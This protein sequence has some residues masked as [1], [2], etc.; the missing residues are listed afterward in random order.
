MKRILI[1]T[2]HLDDFEFGMGGT[3]AK[4]AAES[5]NEIGLVVMC[6]G[7]RPGNEHVADPR[8]EACIY[9]CKQ[10]G[11]KYV[12]I[13]HYPDTRLDKVSQTTVCSDITAIVNEFK[14][15]IVYTHFRDDVHSDHRIVSNAT[16]VACRMR[17]NSTV[18]Q[19]FEFS[20]PGSTEWGFRPFEGNS[21]VNITDLQERKIS[22]IER[23][24]TELRQAPDPISLESICSRDRYTGSLCGYE[25]AES[26]KLIFHRDEKTCVDDS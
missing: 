6:N 15:T 24:T 11:I 9:N 5:D 12:T 8:N 22:L 16:R 17:C 26:F 2:A 10:L 1:I 25:F 4:L 3:V 18:E 23:Y 13:K 14:P 21:Y 19:L 20:I 7:E